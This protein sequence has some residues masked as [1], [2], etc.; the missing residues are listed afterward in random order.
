M[1]ITLFLIA[2]KGKNLI[3]KCPRKQPAATV[4]VYQLFG[5]LS[6]QRC[7]E[8]CLYTIYNANAKLASKTSAKT[9]GAN[10]IGN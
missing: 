2:Q 5:M 3:V 6:L 7:L 9:E 8:S 1:N 10:S 4:T